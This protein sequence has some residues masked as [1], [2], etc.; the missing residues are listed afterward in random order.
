MKTY[1]YLFM[2]LVFFNVLPACSK[3]N[4]ESPPSIEISTVPDAS[5]ACKRKFH[6]SPNSIQDLVSFEYRMQAESRSEICAVTA[7]SGR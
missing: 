1:F 3:A 6:G 5:H 2:I 4:Q 7:V